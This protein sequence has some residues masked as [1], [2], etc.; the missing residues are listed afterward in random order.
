MKKR[1]IGL[2]AAAA[3]VIAAAVAGLW[4]LMQQPL[5]QP[6]MVRAGQNLRAPLAPPAQAGAADFWRV[7]P[8]IQLRH[9]AVGAGRPVL[10]VHGG[11]GYPSAGPWAGLAPLTDRYQFVYYDQRGCGQSTRPFDTF[12]SQNTYENMQTLDRA[13]GLG[14][15]IA[16]IERI[17]H[18]LGQEKLILVGH[19]F[20]GFLAALYAAEFPER[21][22][23]LVL[24]APAE[25]LVMPPPSGG[26]F[27]QVRGRLPEDQR[28]GYDAFLKRYLDFGNLFSRSEAELQALNAEFAP[29]YA[30]AITEPLPAQGAA[31]GWMVQGLYLS[32]GQR[33]DYRSALAA[34]T[35]PALVLHGAQ[36]LQPES[37]S[38]QYVEALPDAQFQVIEAAGHFMFESQPEAFAAAVGQFLDGRP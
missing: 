5:Y 1:L 37:A 24:V 3:V 17:R 11:P 25:L 38:R 10:V 34:V 27:E 29:F 33:H 28:A 22:E 20:G 12:T 6:G 30:A 32:M 14:A 19:S 13:L 31:G 2:L 4:Y 15:Q 18:I 36:D 8:D 7:E 35:A 21:V 23:A 16:D 9:F 26:L